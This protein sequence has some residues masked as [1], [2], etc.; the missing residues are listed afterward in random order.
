M[1]RA[2]EFLQG[3]RFSVL[4]GIEFDYHAQN[5][6]LRMIKGGVSHLWAV[7]SSVSYA[8]AGVHI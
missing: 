3:Q 1:N 4:L 8:I 2:T 5:L 7:K 6:L